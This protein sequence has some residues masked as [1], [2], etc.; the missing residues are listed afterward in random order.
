MKN[1]LKS[2][3][4]AASAFVLLAG[5]NQI[6]V[7]DATVDGA[8]YSE[9]TCYLT[10]GLDDFVDLVVQDRS[11]SRTINPDSLSDAD[12]DNTFSKFVL[13]GKSTITGANLLN[14]SGNE[15][16]E[17]SFSGSPKVA[18]AQIPF[19]AWDLTLE[20]Y[21]KAN[22][23][24]LQG[25]TYVDLKTPK[26]S[27][28]FTL[29]TDNLTTAGSVHVA[30]SFEDDDGVAATYKAGLYSLSDGSLKYPSSLSVNAAAGKTFDLD[31]TSV[32]PG[33]YSFQVRFYN[34]DNKQV[35]F[36]EDIIVVA[37]GRKTE[38][39]G[40]E[41]GKIINQLPDSPTDLMAYVVDGS[42]DEDGNYT[43]I[44]KWSDNSNNEENFV[45][46]I[47][48]YTTS[49]SGNESKSTYAVLGVEPSESDTDKKEIFWSSNKNAGGSI[50]TSSEECRIKLPLGRIFDVSIT[51]QNFVG[52]SKVSDTVKAFARVE[53]TGTVTGA[54]A[55]TTTHINRM[56]IKYDLDNGKLTLASGE[57]KTGV[58]TV[59][60]NFYDVKTEKTVT[61]NTDPA[62]PV[63]TTN[64]KLSNVLLEIVAENA[65]G[66]HLVSG[67]YPFAKWLY[68]N[69]SQI[70]D[71]T[72]LTYEGIEVK[73]SYDNKTG[74]YY[75]VDNKYY[76]VSA[77]AKYGTG[78]DNVAGT[79]FDAKSNDD[80][81]FAV[82]SSKTKK[83]LKASADPENPEYE[84]VEV[85]VDWIRVS[86][87]NLP[88]DT[89]DSGKVSGTSYTFDGTSGLMS[90]PHTV[91]V[92]AHIKDE[93]A[94]TVYEFTFALG[95][96][97]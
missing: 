51:A 48:E 23:V 69:N 66:N 84:D 89:I 55:I 43:V 96:E 88:G 31:L 81:T 13:K 80:I 21:D 37:P 4:L 45:V 33:R 78:S 74:I 57:E 56:A 87:T 50:R 79:S 39:T 24:V 19:G 6:G 17:L 47:D 20:A 38:K 15:G 85:P 5:C 71:T 70:P 49:D 73:A 44:L 9:G 65:N 95:L 92:K 93:P 62:N 22:V 72:E 3:L 82:T 26:S 10:I 30:G 52:E 63:T 68:A 1:L 86:I 29:T 28:A 42:E 40:I 34:T 18:S 32:L 61:D 16:I 7:S 41:C 53:A 67:R 75:T 35:G 77:T 64:L 12:V 36:W 97:R 58:Y 14:D 94:G 27:I 54:T 91:T 2:L 60:R 11:V 83:Q 46:Y 90:G 59:Y 8:A 25:R 76:T